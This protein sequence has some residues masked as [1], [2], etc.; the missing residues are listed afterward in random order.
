MKVLAA[1]LVH[2]LVNFIIGLMVAKYLGPDQFGRFALAMAI[3]MVAQTLCFEWIRQAAIRFYSLKASQEQPQLRA[4]LDMSFAILSACAAAAAIAFILAGWNFSLSNE[5]V[6]LAFVAAITNGL[7]DYK[8][9]L[10]RARFQDGLYGKIVIIKNIL[11]FFLTVGGA[12][13]FQSAAMTVAGMCVSMASAVIFMRGALSDPQARP[14]L[15]ERALAFDHARYA[16]PIITANVLYLAIPLTNRAI[17]SSHYGFAENGQFSLA[18]DIGS[19]LIAAV[20]SALDVLLFQIAV[21]ADEMHGREKAREQVAAN[22]ATIFAILVPSAVGLWLILPSLEHLIVPGEFRG[23]FA[24]YLTLLLP[25]LLA[26]GVMNFAINAFFQ[27]RKSTL[28]L[29]GA[30]LCAC[31]VN[32]GLIFAIASTKDA[33]RFAIAQSGAFVAA[34]ATLAI[35]A[36]ASGARWPR[37]RDLLLTIIAT[38]I[39]AA[40]LYPMRQWPPG[41]FTLAAQIVAG[42]TIFGGLVAVF[43]IAILRSNIM[44]AWR[45]RRGDAP[46][47]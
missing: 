35:F 41:V 21:R 4:T 40:A 16:L 17:I 8:T 30:A 2:T 47:H 13:F 18:F 46:G 6:A 9:A 33:T 25:G 11:A 27:I 3:S 28:P 26:F 10:V 7:F 24:H 37:A 19:R 45:G 15:A 31:L 29:I 5:L 23:P 1:F 39:M 34:F 14:S 36:A 44:N 12:F 20:G 42:A 22:M 38:A 32:A 43:D